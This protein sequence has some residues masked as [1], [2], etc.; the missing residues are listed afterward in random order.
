[1]F[2]KA[3]MIR[4]A[5]KTCK[6]SKNEVSISI[7]RTFYIKFTVTNH[8]ATPPHP[9][10]WIFYQL[11]AIRLN[12]SLILVTYVYGV[13]ANLHFRKCHRSIKLSNFVS[14]VKQSKNKYR[15]IIMFD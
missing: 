3:K 7:Q 11:D 15:K 13:L 1:V 4:G 5:L 12:M 9:P 14:A 6:Y 8:F 2:M 10:P